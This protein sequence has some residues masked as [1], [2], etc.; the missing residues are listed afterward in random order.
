MFKF[1]ECGMLLRLRLLSRKTRRGLR[2]PKQPPSD[3]LGWVKNPTSRAQFSEHH[4]KVIRHSMNFMEFGRI[5]MGLAWFSSF[6]G[7]FLSLGQLLDAWAPQSWFYRRSPA[8]APAFDGGR[9]W[10]FRSMSFWGKFH[11]DDF[12]GISFISWGVIYT[13]Y[14][15]YIYNIYII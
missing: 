12:V 11:N 6:W 8:F 14:I 1:G 9:G 13:I 3:G 5:R 7:L 2:S 15:Q 10:D 4:F